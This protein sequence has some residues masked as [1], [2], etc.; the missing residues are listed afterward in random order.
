MMTTN[1]GTLLGTKKS[2]KYVK[3]FS[4]GEMSGRSFYS[5]Y[6]N[7][8]NGGVVRGLFRSH[9]VDTSRKLAKKALSRRGLV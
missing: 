4:N 5:K 8:E 9:G 2:V 1:W 3:Q 7:T 6:T